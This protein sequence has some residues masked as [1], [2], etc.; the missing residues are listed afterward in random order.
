MNDYQIDPRFP[1][2][3][4]L[5]LR[6]KKRIP[7]FAFEY[8]DGGCNNEV[9]LKKNTSDIRKIELQPHYLKNYG[10]LN[11][12]TSLFGREYDAPFGIAPIGLQGLIWPGATEILAN[13]SKLFN[14]PFTLSTVA[15]ADVEKVA[16][17]TEGKAWFQL[18]HP[19]EKEIRNKLLERIEHAG[20]EVLVVLADVPTFGYRTKEIKNGLSLPPRMNGKNIWQML[21]HPRWSL[22][23]MSHG[24]PEF[25]TLKPYLP[26]NLNLRH[27][28]LFMNKMFSGRV[29]EERIKEIRSLWKGKMVIKGL[30]SPE[31]V[32]RAIEWGADGIII[33]NHGGRQLDPG[34]SSISSLQSI[35]PKYKNKTTIMI[36]GGMRSGTD[37]ACMLAS[38][39]DFCFLGRAPMYGVGALGK[40]G[41]FQ[42]LSI[43]KKELQQVM[44]QI[45]CEN[46]K[47]LSK[48][49]L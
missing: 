46:V 25:K 41:G 29:N 8:L 18:Y 20:Y 27:L 35:I 36:D 5:R 12:K 3:P 47:D 48:H 4:D 21:S 33:S 17:I 32:G 38:G 22:A 19:A 10:G 31:D 23:T 43:L 13:A 16:E 37:I 28:G 6:S 15:T 44:E 42:A 9:N 39:A 7:A 45:G 11:M 49:L 30:A 2:I 26:K 1:S 34:P 40:K 24:R 14:I